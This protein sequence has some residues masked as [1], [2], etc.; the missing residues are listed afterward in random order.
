M[1]ERVLYHYTSAGGLL[2]IIESGTLWA[3]DCR[4]LN[5][6]TELS[7]STEQLLA[8]LS[9]L[10]DDTMGPESGFILPGVV[11]H[12]TAETFRV[13]V[14][15]FCEDGDLLSQWRGYGAD[16]GYAVGLGSDRLWNSEPQ[17]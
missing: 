7:Y 17:A 6:A 1:A 9:T 8:A 14:V 5:D 15:C 10:E 2:G 3:S 16:G 11:E 4:F 13:H 12:L